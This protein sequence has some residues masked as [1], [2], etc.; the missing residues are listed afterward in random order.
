[1]QHHDYDLAAG[2]CSFVKPHLL[3]PES[4]SRGSSETGAEGLGRILPSSATLTLVFLKG[5]TTYSPIRVL[6]RIC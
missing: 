1:M 6:R 2:R 5:I 3:C 4:I